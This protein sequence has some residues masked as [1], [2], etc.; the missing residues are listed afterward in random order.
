MTHKNKLYSVP[1]NLNFFRLKS[2][3]RH[4]EFFSVLHGIEKNNAK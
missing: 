2:G 1:K 4:F 3:D